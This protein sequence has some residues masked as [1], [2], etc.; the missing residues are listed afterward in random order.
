MRCLSGNLLRH[1]R[2]SYVS[3][4]LLRCR[5]HRTGVNLSHLLSKTITSLKAGNSSVNFWRGFNNITRLCTFTLFHALKDSLSFFLTKLFTLITTACKS[6]DAA[7]T[8]LHVAYWQ[9]CQTT[10]SHSHLSFW[11]H[12][13]LRS[14]LWNHRSISPLHRRLLSHLTLTSFL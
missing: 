4:Y 2:S 5:R 13:R 3:F 12:L 1:V 6:N 7:R 10:S 9:R 14:S 11:L 8:K